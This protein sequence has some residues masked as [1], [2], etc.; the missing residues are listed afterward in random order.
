MGKK[1]ISWVE[2]K[3]QNYVNYKGK[4]YKVNF[5][6]KKRFK[7]YMSGWW[8]KTFCRGFTMAG[9]IYIKEGTWLGLDRLVL[10]EIGHILGYEHTWL[11]YIM[12]P[13]WIGRWIMRFNKNDNI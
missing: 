7:M 5:L 9:I 12:F 2:Y 13:S 4:L 1:I 8:Y 3:G 11:P 10:H 6:N